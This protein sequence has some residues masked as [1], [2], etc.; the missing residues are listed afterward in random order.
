MCTDASKKEDALLAGQW[1]CGSPVQFSGWR[2][3]QSASQAAG[4]ARRA[5]F[6]GTAPCR[7]WDR[8]GILDDNSSSVRYALKPHP[9]EY[10]TLLHS[11]QCVCR[12][13]R[14]RCTVQYSIRVY[15]N[16]T[17]YSTAQLNISQ[18][19]TSK[20]WS[21]LLLQY[22]TVWYNVIFTTTWAFA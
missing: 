20:R 13:V 8:A 7:R 21:R 10:S 18:Y 9:V 2:F 22:S 3:G 4:W 5:E 19:S 16:S 14:D 17:H 11:I 12:T 1:A 15:I 6:F